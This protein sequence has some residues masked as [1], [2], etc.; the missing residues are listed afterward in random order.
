MDELRPPRRYCKQKKGYSLNT[1]L[2]RIVENPR[3]FFNMETY[4][5]TTAMR[6]WQRPWDTV[7]SLWILKAR[8]LH[9]L[10]RTHDDT[11]V[12]L[13]RLDGTAVPVVAGVEIYGGVQRH[14]D[15]CKRWQL[16]RT[17]ACRF[18]T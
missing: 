12:S 5:Q 9:I 18:V 8:R 11:H 14:S 17:T 13:G 10:Q 15:F 3:R 2:Q 4:V 6:H 7:N 16:M 1:P